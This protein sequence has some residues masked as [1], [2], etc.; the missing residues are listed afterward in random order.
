MRPGRGFSLPLPSASWV[1]VAAATS[2][3]S[4]S[5]GSAFCGIPL[6]TGAATSTG[7]TNRPNTRSASLSA[8]LKAASRIVPSRGVSLAGRSQRERSPGRKV[9]PA[10]KGNLE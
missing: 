6:R 8:P 10:E 2:A 5:C 7:V 4:R 3:Q 9:E 1:G